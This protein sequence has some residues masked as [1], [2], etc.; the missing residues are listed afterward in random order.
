MIFVGL[1]FRKAVT[2]KSFENLF[3]QV[4]N[5]TELPGPIKALATLDTKALNPALQE[6]AAAKKVTL[7]P[8][9]L[10]NLQRQITPT[11]SLAAQAAYGVGSIAEAAALAAAGDGSLLTFRRLVSNDKLATCAFAKGSFK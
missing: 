10:E 7:I 9:S 4:F 5:L 2:T 1:G 6:F 8:V 3:R 11:Q